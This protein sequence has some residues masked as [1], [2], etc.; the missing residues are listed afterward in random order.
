MRAADFAS[1][2]ADATVR[3]L[4]DN[5]KE[6]I[7]EQLVTDYLEADG[8]FTTSNVK[9]R[10]EPTDPGYEPKQDG[11]H[12]DIDVLGFHPL[13][14]GADRVVAVSCKSWQEGFDPSWEIRA[15]TENRTVGGREAWRRF[16]ELVS[17]KWA[18]A[19]RRAVARRTGSEEFV[20]LTA[21]TR[22]FKAHERSVWE[23]HEPFRTTL[24]CDI[25]VVTLAEMV[26]HVSASLTET[27]ATSELGRTIQLLKAAGVLGKGGV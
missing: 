23:T 24:G 22:L 19:F 17:P 14:T 2:A 7:L 5:M 10:P 20:Y 9:F 16:R 21:V 1:L 6:D 4:K 12:S 3:R 13:K 26:A 15:I 8:Y 18:L 25:R 27:V 11:V